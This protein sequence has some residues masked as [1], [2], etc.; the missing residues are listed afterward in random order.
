MALTTL[1]DPARERVRDERAA[2]IDREAAYAALADRVEELPADQARAQAS[3][4]T[5]AGAGRDLAASGTNGCRA[6]RTAIDETIRPHLDEESVEDALG[7]S[8]ATA[9]SPR[10][11]TALTPRLQR[12]I[13]ATA[14]RRRAETATLVRA[15]D[16]EREHLA[17]AADTVTEITDWIVA[18]DETPLSELGFDALAR[19][20]D[21]LASARAKCDRLAR[22]RQA[23][24]G[25]TTT[26]DGQV[27]VSH[28]SLVTMLAEPLPVEYPL[29][30]TVVRLDATCADCQRAVRAHLVRR[31]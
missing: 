27:A 11:A 3:L 8:I 20:H 13:V 12:S 19:R 30:A 6:V 10:T 2:A 21:R 17:G 31:A 26:T 4:A 24:L 16:R 28:R 23:L 15:L 1:L 18:A 22:E 25:A 7:T 29:L 9:I 5:A 14:E